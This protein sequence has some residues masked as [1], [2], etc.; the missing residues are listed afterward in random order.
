MNTMDTK[1]MEMFIRV[2][3]N[4]PEFALAALEGSHGAALFEQ[5]GQV[6]EDLRSRAH[7]QATGQS[8]VRESSG[9]KAAAYNELIRQLDAMYR[10]AHVIAQKKSGL[11]EKFR[12]PRGVSGQALLTLTRTYGTDAVALKAEFIK[13][14][15]SAN[16]IA[17]LDAAAIAYE[18]AT[19]EKTQ[20]RGRQVAATAEIGRL[21][22][23]GLQLVR[24]LQVV[25][26]NTY[27]DDTSKLTLWMSASHVTKSPRRSRPKNDGNPTPPP[28]PQD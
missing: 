13:R 17:D 25:M 9:N 6:I 8:S 18:T 1:R 20:G 28:P 5:L 24:E 22:E 27:A 15:L 4:R 19:N 16:F 3:E 2:Q 11:E 10:T 23:H 26:H 12:P 14:G 7:D 21:I